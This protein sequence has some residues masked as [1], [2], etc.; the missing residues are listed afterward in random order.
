MKKRMLDTY[1][2]HAR[3]IKTFGK[4]P[5][6]CT[7]CAAVRKERKDAAKKRKAAVPLVERRASRAEELLDDWLRKLSLAAT[8]VRDYQRKVRRYQRQRFEAEIAKA[9]LTPEQVAGVRKIMFGDD[10]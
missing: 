9:H 7:T 3:H 8:K 10:E 2:L 4:G 1:N 5:C 6:R